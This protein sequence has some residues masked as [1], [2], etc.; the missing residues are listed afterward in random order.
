MPLG[1]RE[2]LAAQARVCET[3]PTYMSPRESRH[4]RMRSEKAAGRADVR[5]PQP[6]QPASRAV[7]NAHA[8]RLQA[9]PRASPEGPRS[10]QPGQLGHVDAPL[11]VRADVRG[12]LQVRPLL[13]KAAVEG[14]DLHAIVLPVGHQ[15]PAVVRHPECHGADGTARARCPALPRTA[16]AALPTE[17]RWILAL[18]YPSETYRSPPGPIAMLVG[19]LNGGPLRAMVS[20]RK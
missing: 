19:L 14:K 6:R 2:G 1:Q 12:P 5:R 17:K 7:Q 13:Q 20:A 4:R 8:A 3:S 10:G 18:P 9:L 16:E 11:P 15:H